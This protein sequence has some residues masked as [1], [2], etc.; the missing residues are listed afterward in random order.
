MTTNPFPDVISQIDWKHWLVGRCRCSLCYL[1]VVVLYS[2]FIPS[3]IDVSETARAERKASSPAPG[4]CCLLLCRAAPLVLC[5]AADNIS[6]VSM[7]ARCI[8][9]LPSTTNHYCSVQTVNRGGGAGCVQSLFKITPPRGV[10]VPPP[11]PRSLLQLP[12]T[13]SHPEAA[14]ARVSAV[15][16]YIRRFTR[17]IYIIRHPIILVKPRYRGSI[18]PSSYPRFYNLPICQHSRIADVRVSSVRQ[19]Q[20]RWS[21]AVPWPT[22]NIFNR[23]DN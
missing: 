23:M 11:P 13:S 22:D 3:N 7:S 14:Q 4:E 16:R 17:Y 8:Q 12:S 20:C 9:S 15:P 19:Q 2:P 6:P 21:E 5:R 18:E 10:L 1:Q